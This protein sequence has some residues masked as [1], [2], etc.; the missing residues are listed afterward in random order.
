M[1]KSKSPNK[2]SIEFRKSIITEKNLMINKPDSFKTCKTILNE[3]EE[4]FIV[5]EMMNLTFSNVNYSE[6]GR[7]IFFYL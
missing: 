1:S 7:I 2:S 5:K 4:R 3:V 6:L